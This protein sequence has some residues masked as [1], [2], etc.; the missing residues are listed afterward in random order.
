MERPSP[1]TTSNTAAWKGLRRGEE[2][3]VLDGDLVIAHG[4]VEEFT[5]D[6]KIIWLQL[7]YGKGRRMFHHD[8]GWCLRPVRRTT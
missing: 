8:D 3:E 4:V 7:S 2:I 1:T 5:A 6:Q